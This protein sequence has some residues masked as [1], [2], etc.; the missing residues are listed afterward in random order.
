MHCDMETGGFATPCL[1]RLD[2]GEHERGL[3]VE[4]EAL[5]APALDVSALFEI[6]VQDPRPR[7]YAATDRDLFGIVCAVGAKSD[8]LVVRAFVF[9][10]AEQKFCYVYLTNMSEKVTVGRVARGQ[11]PDLC[12]IGRVA[13]AE[14]PRAG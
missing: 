13:L 3:L 6:R 10:G 9:R 7:P 4:A 12:V 1:L 2:G 11:P 8:C 14:R 5:S